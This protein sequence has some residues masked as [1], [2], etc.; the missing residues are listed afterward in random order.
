V[1]FGGGAVLEG[2]SAESQL[3]DGNL[4]CLETDGHIIGGCRREDDEA[5]GDNTHDVERNSKA[6]SG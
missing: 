4:V 2:E 6:Q 5:F 1:S 3:N